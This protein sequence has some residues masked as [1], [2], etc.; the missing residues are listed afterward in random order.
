MKKLIV[1]ILIASASIIV[2]AQVMLS[3][4]KIIS[5]DKS[6]IIVR[7]FCLLG[8]QFITAKQMGN[9]GVAVVQVFEPSSGTSKP[10]NCKQDTP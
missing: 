6:A 5:I 10:M 2:T 9:Q 8:M 1:G 4:E 3:Q 7:P